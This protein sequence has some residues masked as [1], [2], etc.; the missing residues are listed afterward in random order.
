MKHPVKLRLDRKT[1]MTV[2]GKRHDFKVR[3]NVGFSKNGKING[4]KIILLSNGGNVLDLSGP[5][6]TRALTH[7]DNCYSFKNFL[8]KDIFVKQIQF[9]ILLLEVLVVLKVCLQLKIF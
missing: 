2:S 9:Q 4:I 5:V 7:L 8:Q 1:D 6:M 3:Y